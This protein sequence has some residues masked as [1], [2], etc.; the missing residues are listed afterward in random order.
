MVQPWQ[1]RLQKD[2]E[3]QLWQ[4]TSTDAVKSLSSPDWSH[5]YPGVRIQLLLAT[6][7][8]IAETAPE[9]RLVVCLKCTHYAQIMLCSFTALMSRSKPV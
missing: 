7:H 9:L 4:L 1:P 5:F 3:W 8:L 2:A 6:H